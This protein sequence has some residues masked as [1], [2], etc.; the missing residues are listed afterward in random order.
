[1]NLEHVISDKLS[2]VARHILILLK[3]QCR[4]IYDM[5][6]DFLDKGNMH[7]FKLRNEVCVFS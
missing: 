1:M 6:S 7:F 4:V 5:T 3:R 2:K